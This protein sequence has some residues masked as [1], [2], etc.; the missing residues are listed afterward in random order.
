MLK[1]C[2]HLVAICYCFSLVLFVFGPTDKQALGWYGS[3][4]LRE[5]AKKEAKT[6]TWQRDRRP[7]YLTLDTQLLAGVCING[8]TG[9]DNQK[10]SRKLSEREGGP[11]TCE[12]LSGS[13]SHLCCFFSF[14]FS[15]LFCVF[16]FV[17]FF[18]LLARSKSD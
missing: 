1:T 14:L 7:C 12:Y 3:W 8:M 9:F 11:H 18:Y 4:E 10:L 17:C 15:C 16:F 5:F 13:I 2:F 6:I